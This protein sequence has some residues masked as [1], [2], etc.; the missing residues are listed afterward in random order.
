MR[1]IQKLPFQI[2]YRTIAVILAILAIIGILL[3]ANW[4]DGG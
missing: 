1:S 2:S 3:L 4:M